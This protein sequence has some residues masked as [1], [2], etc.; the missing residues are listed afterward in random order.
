MTR[1]SYIYCTSSYDPP[2]PPPLC[3]FFI[4]VLQVSGQWRKMERLLYVRHSC[5]GS[6]HDL[7]LFKKYRYTTCNLQCTMASRSLA[8]ELSLL[9]FVFLLDFQICICSAC[10]LLF[11]KF[12]N[13]LSFTLNFNLDLLAYKHFSLLKVVNVD[14]Q[15][16]DVSLRCA[17]WNEF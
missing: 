8:A 2:P 15:L 17:T 5:Y 14:S 10:S 3:F 4:R 9:Y 6:W 13:L 12:F 1:P 16:R 11:N 7:S